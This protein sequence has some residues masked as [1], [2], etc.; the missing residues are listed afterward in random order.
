VPAVEASVFRILATC[1]AVATGSSAPLILIIVFPRSSPLLTAATSKLE[2][3]A[4]PLGTKVLIAAVVAADAAT[5]AALAAATATAPAPMA[6]ELPEA[7]DPPTLAPPNG[8][9]EDGTVF[10]PLALAL[11][12]I[13]GIFGRRGILLY[14]FISPFIF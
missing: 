11:V 5:E 7:L 3:I 8:K 6:D 9:D 1:R 10:D 12:P 2:G 14:A 4:A 13:V